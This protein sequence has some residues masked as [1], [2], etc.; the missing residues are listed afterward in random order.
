MRRARPAGRWRLAWRSSRRWR[1]AAAGRGGRARS[2]RRSRP[3]PPFAGRTRPPRGS[4]LVVLVGAAAR[5]LGRETLVRAGPVGVREALVEAAPGRGVLLDVDA[6]GG[7]E[8]E[9]DVADGD[10]GAPLGAELGQLILDAQALE[11]IGQVADGLVVVEL[12][13]PHP[14]LGLL[15]AHDK[16]AR[17]VGVGCDGEPGVV[18]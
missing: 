8:V 16:A 12:R 1:P 15:A 3:S 4:F 17:V 6:P 14:A 10:R 7:F 2:A 9:G 5:L 11:P 13:L 18:D